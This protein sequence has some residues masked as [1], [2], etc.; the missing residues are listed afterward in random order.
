MWIWIPLVLGIMLAFVEK[1]KAS[2]A[3]L[4][5]TLL[6]AIV[7]Q[8]LNMTGCIGVIIG[9]LVAYKAPTLDRR[10]QMGAYAFVFF[11]CIALFLHL[12]PGFN[13]AK[14]LDSV[15]SGPLSL[16]YTLYLN[17]D[18]PLIFFALLLAYPGLLGNKDRSNKKALMLTAIPLFSLLP[19][20]WG[21][22][23]LKPEFTLPSW[24]WLFALNN[25]FLTCVAEEAFFRGF[26]QQMLTKRFNWIVGIAVAS[27]LFGLVHIGGG[28]LLVLFATFTGVGYGLAFHFSSRLWVAVLFHFFFNFFHLVFFT[29]P[30]MIP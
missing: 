9:L 11:W 5:L 26:L 16:P 23:A 12:I 29:Y 7:E 17:L 15:I 25:L 4:A 22:G 20:A 18:K 1:T 3:L 30:L 14:V 27:I 28:L 6:G 21:L 13:N 2:F 8:R 10:W 24:W 19:I